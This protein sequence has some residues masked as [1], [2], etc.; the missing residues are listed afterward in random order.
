ME[1]AVTGTRIGG[2]ALLNARAI[3][4][5]AIVRAARDRKRE[6]KRLASLVVELV[7]R[8][9]TIRRNRAIHLPASRRRVASFARAEAASQPFPMSSRRAGYRKFR[10]LTDQRFLGKRKLEKNGRVE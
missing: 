10:L 3:L 6:A 5:F 7:V 8:R 1:T 2:G 4:H 9:A